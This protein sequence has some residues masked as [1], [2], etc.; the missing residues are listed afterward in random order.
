[1][2]KVT[3]QLGRHGSCAESSPAASWQVGFHDFLNKIEILDTEPDMKGAY[4]GKLSAR[5]IQKM[6]VKS[7]PVLIHMH[8]LNMAVAIAGMNAL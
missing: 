4:H 2:R 6:K 8:I 3:E 5:D 7:T 1:M